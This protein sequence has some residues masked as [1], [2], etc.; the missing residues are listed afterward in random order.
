MALHIELLGD[1]KKL[2]SGPA[3]KVVI[4]SANGTME[5]LPR[6]TDFVVN[7]APGKISIY[8]EGKKVAKIEG[9][10]GVAHKKDETVTILVEEKII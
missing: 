4:P 8:N 10:R 7:L 9:Q 1:T 3:T 6:H 5:I 2:Y